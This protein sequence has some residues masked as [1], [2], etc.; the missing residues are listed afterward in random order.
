MFD[1]VYH[2]PQEE[3]EVT[4]KEVGQNDEVVERLETVKLDF[5]DDDK[6]FVHVDGNFVFAFMSLYQGAPNPNQANLYTKYYLDT[7][8]TRQWL[9]NVVALAEGK[10]LLLFMHY[11]FINRKC[12][13]TNTTTVQMID[14]A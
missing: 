11:P 2:Q 3:V 13:D 9:K 7:G 5:V 10:T 14:W 12:F 4:I 1:T 6:N 8:N